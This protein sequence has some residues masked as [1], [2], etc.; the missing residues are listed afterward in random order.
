[1][2]AVGAVIDVTVIFFLYILGLMLALATESDTW[3]TH[4]QP[5]ITRHALRTQR[6]RAHNRILLAV[7]PAT[8][9]IEWA[10]G[11]LR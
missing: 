6:A 9:P 3:R 8:S 2:R 4:V 5:I 1:M 11:S 7:T 10:V